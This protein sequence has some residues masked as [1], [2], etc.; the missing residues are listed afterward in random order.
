MSGKS[1]LIAALRAMYQA[2]FGVVTVGCF[3][4]RNHICCR[5]NRASRDCSSSFELRVLVCS[6][7]TPGS[8]SL[9][10]ETSGELFFSPIRVLL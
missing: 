10:N 4:G 7:M 2:A 5:G 8:I 9:Q 3:A 1:L 6:P